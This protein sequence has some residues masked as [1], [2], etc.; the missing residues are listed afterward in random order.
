MTEQLLERGCIKRIHV[1][2]Q[3]LRKAIAGEDVA[4]YIVQHKGKSHPCK[5]WTAAGPFTGVNAIN[6]PLSCGAR[7]YIETTGPMVLYS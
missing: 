1:H 5:R 7:L 6:K 2:Q 3:K 4:P